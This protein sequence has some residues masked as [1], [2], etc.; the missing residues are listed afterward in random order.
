M[1]PTENSGNVRFKTAQKLQS[2]NPSKKQN[3]EIN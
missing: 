3:N 1:H 2:I